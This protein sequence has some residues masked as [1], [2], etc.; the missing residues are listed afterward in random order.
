MNLV[1]AE[2]LEMSEPA[3]RSY[4]KGSSKLMEEAKEKFPKVVYRPATKCYP[5]L[6]ALTLNNVKRPK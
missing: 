4:Q 5:M 2:V 3:F 6:T 1:R